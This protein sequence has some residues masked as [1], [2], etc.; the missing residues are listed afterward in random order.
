MI[1]PNNYT[2]R[3][4]KLISLNEYT[5]KELTLQA[6]HFGLSLQA[7]IEQILTKAAEQAEEQMLLELAEEGDQEIIHGSEKEQFQK[8]LQ[9]LSLAP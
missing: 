1:Q 2:G 9:S 3:V 7:Y 5:K 8:Y 6:V 4:S